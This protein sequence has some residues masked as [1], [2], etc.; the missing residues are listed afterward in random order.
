MLTRGGIATLQARVK[1]IAGRRSL[2]EAN[3]RQKPGYHLRPPRLL[4][5]NG[6][7]G[8]LSPQDQCIDYYQSIDHNQGYYSRV[9]NVL[10]PI[11][12]CLAPHDPYQEMGEKHSLLIK[13]LTLEIK[14][15]NF[16]LTL[17]ASSLEPPKA[18]SAEVLPHPTKYHQKLSALF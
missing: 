17:A 12:L 5:A 13:V 14:L 2:S 7:Q 1:R 3:M 11:I 18:G 15:T 4:N 6:T 9:S 16:P 10:F 8:S